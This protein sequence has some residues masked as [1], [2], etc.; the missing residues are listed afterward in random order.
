MSGGPK[1]KGNFF[2]LAGPH[3]QMA[4]AMAEAGAE[5]LSPHYLDLIAPH[6]L[7]FPKIANTVYEAMQAARPLSPESDAE[8]Q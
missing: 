5:A 7:F 2:L 8:N 3:T 4:R 6:R 1:T